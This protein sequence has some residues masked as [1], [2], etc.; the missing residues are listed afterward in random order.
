MATDSISA[1]RLCLL[2]A[3]YENV[4]LVD[5]LQPANLHTYLL[6]WGKKPRAHPR[7]N[8]RLKEMF[9]RVWTAKAN[10]SSIWRSQVDLSLPNQ[11]SCEMQ[12]PTAVPPGQL[13]PPGQPDGP[14]E[15][16]RSKDEVDE[17]DG[18]TA[19]GFEVRDLLKVSSDRQVAIDESALAVGQT[20]RLVKDTK[21]DLM[22]VTGEAIHKMVWV[23]LWLAS[24][25][26]RKSWHKLAGLIVSQ[27]KREW[28]TDLVSTKACLLRVITAVSVALDQLHR[29]W[30]LI[31]LCSSKAQ[32]P[33]VW[34]GIL[35][36]ANLPD[37]E[38][39]AAH[40]PA[41]NPIC[42]LVIRDE[43]Q[44]VEPAQSS[45]STDGPKK[46]PYPFGPMMHQELGQA[47]SATAKLSKPPPPVKRILRGTDPR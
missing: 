25:K 6:L 15:A 12:Q 5:C 17:C 47:P 27:H 3:H 44:R 2:S 10:I 7:D 9:L 23:Q 1:A 28:Q 43:P 31:R 11:G 36:A 20:R 34:A 46:R 42:P 19:L 40:D 22:Q 13:Q 14:P 29:P 45:G 37:Y 32:Q 39:V 18:R 35:R 26:A 30:D 4:D 33:Q 21:E 8:G 24:F 16:V 38:Y 41:R